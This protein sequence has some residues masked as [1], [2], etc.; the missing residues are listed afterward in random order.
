MK[1]IETYV[2]EYCG[3]RFNMAA[4]CKACEES[5]PNLDELTLLDTQF[6]IGGET[7]FPAIVII[8]S[9]RDNSEVGV[10]EF[11]HREQEKYYG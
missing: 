4:D 6:H 5:H 10:Y 9:D 7:A 11:I 2:C 8:R 3:D 1:I